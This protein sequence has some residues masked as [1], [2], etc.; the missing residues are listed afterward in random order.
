MLSSFFI[1]FILVYI[2]KLLS[3]M[4]IYNWPFPSETLQV[5]SHPFF[6]S[7]PASYDRIY[8]EVSL[9]SKASCMFC[10]LLLLFNDFRISVVRK[11][12]KIS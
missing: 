9:I 12:V 7:H 4:G 10:V 6:V 3:E 8:Q 11:D 1:L 5:S 2:Y